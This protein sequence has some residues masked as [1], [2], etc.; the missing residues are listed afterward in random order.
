MYNTVACEND[1]EINFINL[2][3]FKPKTKYYGWL[4]TIIK[5]WGIGH[6]DPN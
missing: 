4:R 5:S 3:F 6:V 2:Q 1:F